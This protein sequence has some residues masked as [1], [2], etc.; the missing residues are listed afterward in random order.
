MELKAGE[1]F[2][3]LTEGQYFIYR[4][5]TGTAFSLDGGDT[6]KPSFA[7]VCNV[8]VEKD[9]HVQIPLLNQEGR[10]NE[11]LAPSCV[12]IG[13]NFRITTENGRFSFQHWNSAILEWEEMGVI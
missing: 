13:E 10:L 9:G 12:M 3:Y 8:L 4:E 5:V 6:W 11:K 2:V 7:Y 1:N